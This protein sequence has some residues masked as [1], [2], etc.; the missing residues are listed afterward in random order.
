MRVVVGSVADFGPGGHSVMANGRSVALFNVRGSFFA[1]RDVCPHRGAAL[2]AGCVVGELSSTG[3]GSYDFNPDRVF[4]RCPWHGWEYD[5]RTGQ[6]FH[7]PA[8]DRVR[9]YEVRVEPGSAIAD[10]TTEDKSSQGRQPGPYT[11][12][13]FSVTV[14]DDYVVLEM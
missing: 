10:A 4:V 11:V 1:V 13:R 2:S 3:P 6:S 14:E 12:E 7:S 9:A 8:D 5:L